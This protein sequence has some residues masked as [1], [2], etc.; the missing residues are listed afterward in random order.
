MYEYLSGYVWTTPNA[1]AD[2]ETTAEDLVCKTLVFGFPLYWESIQVIH[3]EN[4]VMRSL[5]SALQVQHC[6]TLAYI[7]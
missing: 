2:A 5:Q 4:N 1:N 6:F 3:F 7:P